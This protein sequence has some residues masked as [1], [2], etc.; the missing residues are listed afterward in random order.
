MVSSS[1]AIHQPE[2]APKSPFSP[3]G[4]KVAARPD[5]GAFVWDGVLKI[6]PHPSPLPQFFASIL[7][8]NK[9]LSLRKKIGGEGAT[10]RCPAD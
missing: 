9:M 4:E 3:A 10:G 2:R 8:T 7:P 5:E 1:F 6:P